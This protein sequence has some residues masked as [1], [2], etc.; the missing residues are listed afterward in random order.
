V[1]IRTHLDPPVAPA[2]VDEV[3]G[4]E[5]KERAAISRDGLLVCLDE[6]RDASFLRLTFPAAAGLDDPSFL[7]AVRHT[8]SAIG[9]ILRGRGELPWR[10][11]NYVPGIR[12]RATG[13]A[14]RYEV[15]NEGR[16]AGYEEWG[17]LEV[18]GNR[19]AAA[20]GVDHR[21]EDLVVHVLAGRAPAI[22]IE[23][24]RQIPA[25][26]YSRR[27]GPVA[28]CFSRASLLQKVPPAWHGR[29]NVL[30]A[31]T[32]SIV[33]E[34]SRHP[35]DLDAQLRE[36][37]LNLAWLSA[38]LAGEQPPSDAGLDEPVRGALA[39]YGDL[40]AYVVRSED[41]DAVLSGLRR[42]FPGLR[43]LELASADLCRPELLVEVEGTLSLE[44]WA[45]R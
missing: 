10:L 1:V 4:A 15:F 42:A 6:S 30:V 37:L 19:F 22:P 16:H 36:T 27:Y 14:S 24:P 7:D 13:A 44:A 17:G 8:Y 45:R 40:R 38:T 20:S 26:R 25:Y 3:L 2:W 5:V 33:G 11:W 43:S 29:R 21:G 28:P 12:R 18:P 9:S 35:G 39:R 41:A 31:G 34:D 23:N 32:G